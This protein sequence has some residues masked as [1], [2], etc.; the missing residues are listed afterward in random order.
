M[1]R[2]ND[3]ASLWMRRFSFEKRVGGGMYEAKNT[4]RAL[5][6]IGYDG[7]VHKTFRAADAQQRFDNEVKVLRYLEQ[8]G[9]DFVPKLLEAHPDELRIVTTTCGARVQQMSEEKIK[10]VYKELE[11]Y[12]VRHEDPFLRNITY[13]AT[14][15]RFCLIDFEFATILD[16]SVNQP[17]ATNTPAASVETKKLEGVRWSG[18]THIG[19]FRPNNEDSFLSITFDSREFHYLG[20]VGEI[21]ASGLDFVFAVSDGMGGEKSG[22]FASRFAVDNI[23]RL[24]PR[25]FDI[26]PTNYKLE[27]REILTE[28][29]LLTHRQLTNLG[30]SYA[31]GKNMGATLS[32]LWYMRGWIN[33]AHIGDSRIYHLPAEGGM[34][35]ITEDHTHV[36]W[37]RRKGKLNER[38][39]RMHPRKNVLSQSLGS[40]N[41]IIT[42]QIGRLPCRAGDKFLLCTDG[43]IEGLWDR[44]L[45]DILRNPPKPEAEVPLAQQVVEAALAESGR[46]NTTAMVVEI[47]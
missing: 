39:S 1:I 9:C 17:E 23:T 34:Q 30:N 35:Q 8:R 32:L 37:L 25:R 22:E 21:R 5:V 2:I 44:A 20:R 10:E 7:R 41:Q 33:F 12:G 13:R 15:G 46:D 43:V 24:L 45:Q 40:G 42:P 4:A 19:Y 38:E 31:E 6:R 29:F 16:E 27:F 28:L 11:A 26:P 3:A 47:F 14:D 18:M 36:G